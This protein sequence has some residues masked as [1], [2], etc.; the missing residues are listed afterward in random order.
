MILAGLACVFMVFGTS[1]CGDKAPERPTVADAGDAG[2]TDTGTEH[3]PD[4]DVADTGAASLCAPESADCA[5]AEDCLGYGYSMS[6][7]PSN[8]ASCP[9]YST[10][11]CV[12]GTC[13]TPPRVPASA[14][15]NL[16][17]QVS[18]GL[19]ASVKSFAGF[20]MDRTTSSG[21]SL[22]CAD[23]DLSLKAEACTNIVDTRVLASIARA[24]E[25]Y[26][27]TFTRFPA[28]RDVLM[29]VVGYDEA[30]AEGTAVGISCTEYEVCET[31]EP[32]LQVIGGT[33]MSAL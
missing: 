29:I 11:L 15:H 21:Q 32:E 20:I 7:P 3:S 2:L 10:T 30:G 31:C 14:P 5:S 1:A 22:S 25:S 8:C 33:P 13:Q 6:L 26:T 24:D 16:V 12:F 27:M 4:A 18:T 28:G 17:F 23:F 9:K 19:R